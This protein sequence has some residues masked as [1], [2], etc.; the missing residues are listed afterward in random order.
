MLLALIGYRG[1]GKSTVARQ[2]ALAL[3]WEWI[4]LDVEVELLAGKS[5][6]AIFADEGEAKFRDLESQALAQALQRDRTVL[7]L[8]GGAVLQPENRVALAGRAI[9]VWLRATPETILHRIAA[10]PTTSER[11]PNLTCGGLAEIEELLAV[12]EPLYRQCADL[13][14]D[15]DLA[16]PADVAAEVLNSP[17]VVAL[18]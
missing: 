16:S 2:L 10:D 11:R 5:I 17:Q 3:G 7:A 8:G 9:V 15:T 18:R 1:T 6:A 12:R 14:V 13:T 4:D